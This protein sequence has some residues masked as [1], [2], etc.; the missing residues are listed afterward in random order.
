[1][2]PIDSSVDVVEQTNALSLG[3]TFENPISP[4]LVEGTTY[5]LI[6]HG[7]TADSFYIHIVNQS[8]LVCEVCPDWIHPVS[9]FLTRA[10]TRAVSPSL[11]FPRNSLSIASSLDGSSVGFGPNFDIG[12]E[13]LVSTS[14]RTSSGRCCH[15]AT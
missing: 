5:H 6:A 15:L 11:D 14:T 1:M 10:A 13:D 8:S 9:P 12:I 7:F 3:D 2:G 4:S